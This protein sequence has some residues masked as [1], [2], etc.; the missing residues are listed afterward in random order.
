MDRSLK[1]GNTKG[2]KKHERHEKRPLHPPGMRENMGRDLTSEDLWCR[3]ECGMFMGGNLTPPPAPP[4]CG[5][6]KDGAPR[7]G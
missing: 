4:R 7:E 6:G 3:N 5:R 2:T 1:S